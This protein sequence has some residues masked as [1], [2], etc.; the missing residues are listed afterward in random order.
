M[1]RKKTD[2]RW[3]RLGF[4][5]SLGLLILAALLP[6]T[7]GIIEGPARD[8]RMWRCGPFL[9]FPAAFFSVVG[10]VAVST[11]CTVFGIAR[12]NSCE[13]IGWC[14]LGILV[15]LMILGA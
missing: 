14:L 2:W 12:R 4:A 1:E 11:G 10:A 5:L 8:P 7:G 3:L 15:F 13:I 6:S 9:F